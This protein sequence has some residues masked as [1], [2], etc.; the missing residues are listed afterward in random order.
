M[1]RQQYR[2][3]PKLSKTFLGSSPLFTLLANSSHLSPISLP[4]EKQRTGMIILLNP[5][6]S[7]RKCQKLISCLKMH[8]PLKNTFGDEMM[9]FFHPICSFSDP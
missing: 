8:F 4:Q 1:R 3:T 9:T 7:I 5:P 2:V 6:L